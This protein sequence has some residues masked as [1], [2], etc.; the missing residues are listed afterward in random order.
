MGRRRQ[1]SENQTQANVRQKHMWQELP[2]GRASQCGQLTLF[3]AQAPLEFGAC[4]I[5]EASGGCFREVATGK[6]QTQ[7]AWGKKEKPSSNVA[8]LVNMAPVGAK[9]GLGVGLG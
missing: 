6:S 1:S 9:P 8:S 3:G 5:Q 2:E 4:G 7:R